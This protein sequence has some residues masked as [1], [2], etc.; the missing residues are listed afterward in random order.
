MKATLHAQAEAVGVMSTQA[1]QR[2]NI[3]MKPA[4]WEMLE[5]RLQAACTTLML[6]NAARDRPGIAAFLAEIEGGA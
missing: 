4:Q 5:P 1:R 2:G 6:L 3:K